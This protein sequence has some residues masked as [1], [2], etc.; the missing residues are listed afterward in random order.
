MAASKWQVYHNAKKYMVDG[1]I[2]LDTATIVMKILADSKAAVVSAFTRDTFASLTA[3]VFSASATRALGSKSL[4]LT[5][6]SILCFDSA[7]VVFT[8]SA[9]VSSIQYAVI[10]ITGGKAIAWCK[11]TATPI[12]LAAG[13]TLTITPA[14]TGYFTFSGGTTA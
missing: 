5:A 10:G 6:N 11:L 13:N 9:G 7:A 4:R 3:L 8:A 12:S 1:T 2:D 14:A